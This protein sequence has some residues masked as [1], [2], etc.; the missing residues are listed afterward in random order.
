MKKTG[1]PPNAAKYPQAYSEWALKTGQE[2]SAVIK[3]KAPSIDSSRIQA[4]INSLGSQ[5]NQLRNSPE[6]IKNHQKFL[7]YMER[8]NVNGLNTFQLYQALGGEAESR[9]VQARMNFL[10]SQ[11]QNTYPGA[12]YDVRPGVTYNA[13][14]TDLFNV[15]P[16]TIPTSARP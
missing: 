2:L 12:S 16:G 14:Y 9:A 13:L 10:L 6:F 3:K 1:R 11:R 5:L 8:Q 4:E 15:P 7:D